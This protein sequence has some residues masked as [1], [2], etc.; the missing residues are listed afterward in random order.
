MTNRERILSIM[1]GRPPDRIPWIPR[2]LL[3]YNAHT[4]AGSLPKEFRDLSLREIQREL[5]LGDPA[6]DGHVFQTSLDGVQVRRR[7]LNEMEELTEYDTPAGTV[8]TRQQGSELLRQAG[9]ADLQVDFA[10]KGREDYAAVEYLVEHNSYTPTYEAYE[11]YE[12]DIGDDGYPLVACGDCPFHSWMRGWAGYGA[13]YYHL[14]D[15]PKEVESL[16]ALMTQRD[17]E[18]VWPLIADS[19]AKL[20]L[21]GVHFSSQMTPPPIYERF[22]LPYYRELSEILRSRGKTLVLHGDNDT[23]QILSHIDRSGFRMVECF[24]NH[25]MVETTLEEA[26]AAWGKR[27][28]IWGGVPSTILEDPYSDSEF[29]EYMADM[30]RAIAPGDA[31]I[32]GV[33]D[34]VMPGAKLDRVRRITEMVGK[35]GRYPVSVDTLQL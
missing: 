2:L 16:L 20:I 3:W 12:R 21:H 1:A 14:N 35:Y 8:S 23:R 13:A 24:V 22:I 5:G 4:R 29:E 6:R 33:A 34:N 9:I 27:I 25:P 30:F 26:R 15:Y 17:R 11:D 32:M 10:L 28:I 18:D 31:F 7:K 19:P